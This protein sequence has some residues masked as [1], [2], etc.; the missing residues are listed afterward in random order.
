M[1]DL[2]DDAVTTEFDET[3]RQ[4]I[5]V[6]DLLS[7]A[8]CKVKMQVED[9]QYIFNLLRDAFELFFKNAILYEKEKLFWEPFLLE[10]ERQRRRFADHVGLIFLLRFVIFIVQNLSLEQ[11]GATC[12]K[13]THRSAEFKK[14]KVQTLSQNYH[15]VFCVI[16]HELSENMPLCSSIIR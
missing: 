1:I 2:L 10:Y 12:D 5:S 11:D 6:S 15:D 16:I 13:S 14:S 7:R 8:Q 9:A 3:P 4:V